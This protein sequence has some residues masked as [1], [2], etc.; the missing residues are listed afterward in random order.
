MTQ[1]EFP[2][3]HDQFSPYTDFVKERGVYAGLINGSRLSIGELVMEDLNHEHEGVRVMAEQ[4]RRTRGA[5]TLDRFPYGYRDPEQEPYLMALHQ[6]H[7]GDVHPSRTDL[8][9]AAPEGLIAVE[10][11][12]RSERRQGAEFIARSLVASAGT[13]LVVTDGGLLKDRN[14]Q[15]HLHLHENSRKLRISELLTDDISFTGE[16][17]KAAAGLLYLALEGKQ[18]GTKMV[19]VECPPDYA[20]EEQR[21]APLFSGFSTKEI[22]ADGLFFA[23]R[24]SIVRRYLESRYGL[25]SGIIKEQKS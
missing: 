13:H 3:Q 10:D 6:L 4:I 8:G 2:A 9:I 17:E 14:V 11:L 15:G 24:T 12:P 25:R 21:R 18:S 23:G 16:H 5:D 7:R 20:T 22:N 1:T 19:T